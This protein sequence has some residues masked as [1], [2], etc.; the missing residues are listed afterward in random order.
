[1]D[2]LPSFTKRMRWFLENRRDLGGQISY[3]E[4]LVQD[5][6]EHRLLAIPSRARL[7]R[8]LR[9]VLDEKEF[10]SPYGVRSLSAIHRDHPYRIQV[11]G[12]DYEVEYAPG[13]A[14]TPLFGGNSNWRGPVWFPP[15]YLLAE[16]LERYHHFYG[17]EF[18]VEC[19]VGSGRRMNLGEVAQEL[20]RRLAGLF[21]P[22]AQGNRPSHGGERRYAEDPHWKDLVQFYEYFHGDNGRGMGANHQTGWTALA[23]R[24]IEDMV[25]GRISGGHTTELPTSL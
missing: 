9:Y 21:L 8:V 25:R 2:R 5:G 19:P 6:H 7:E 14:T 18:T 16:S 22:D 12:A 1:L 3:M 4:S 11:K 10:L 24:C 23:A 15:N 13:E 20:N 17:G